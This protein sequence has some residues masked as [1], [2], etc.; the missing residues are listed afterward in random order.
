M[1]REH[2][3]P[4]LRGTPHVLPQHEPPSVAEVRR[5]YPAD[6]DVRDVPAAVTEVPRALDHPTYL[7]PHRWGTPAW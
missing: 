6:V 1:Q 2:A 7:R 4:A 5:S 3:T